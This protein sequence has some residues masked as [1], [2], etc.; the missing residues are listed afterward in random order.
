MPGAASATAL[1]HRGVRGL[2]TC[3]HPVTGRPPP[4]RAARRDPAR[5][6][7]QHREHR[8]RIAEIGGDVETFR[9]LAIYRQQQVARVGRPLLRDSK[10]CQAHGR[11]QFPEQGALPPRQVDRLVEALLGSSDMLSAGL[12]E[13]K[14]APDALEL[15]PVPEVVA[16]LAADQRIVGDG[17]PLRDIPGVAEAGCVC[18]GSTGST[19]GAT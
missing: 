6:F 19:D 1:R 8:S 9:I 3:R 16:A 17:E 18:D 13:Q 15:G 12:A 2:S 14:F 5:L 4:S 7:R 10:P 11:S